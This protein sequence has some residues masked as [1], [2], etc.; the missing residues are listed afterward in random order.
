M[1]QTVEAD[2]LD[3]DQSND[4]LALFDFWQTT[5]GADVCS[6]LVVAHLCV[7]DLSVELQSQGKPVA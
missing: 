5:S 4:S 7:S 6:K 3:S 2:M 1:K